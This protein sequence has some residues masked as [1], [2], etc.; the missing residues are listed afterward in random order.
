MIFFELLKT[1]QNLTRV[2][3]FPW[4]YILAFVRL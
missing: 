3:I 1:F 4:C 2:E